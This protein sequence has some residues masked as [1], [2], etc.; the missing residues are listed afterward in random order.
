[1]GTLIGSLSGYLLGVALRNQ[2]IPHYL[3]NTAVLTLILGAFAFSNVFAHESGL[4]TVTIAGMILAN[5]RN[6]N[7]DGILEFNETL[8][9]L[10]ISALFILLAT[11]IDF[12]A[13]EAVG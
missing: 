5:M 3:Q 1:M 13:I 7:V 12:A 11:R 8:S 6:V 4:L 9:V 2:W 10:L